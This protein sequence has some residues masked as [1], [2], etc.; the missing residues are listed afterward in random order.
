MIS[1]RKLRANRANSLRSTGPKTAAGRATAAR[2]ARRHGLRIPV[3]SDPA[4]SAE[5]EALAQKIAGNGSPELV[6]LAQKI[7]EAE[8]DVIRVRRARTDLI[9]RI[10]SNLRD[11]TSVDPG[12]SDRLADAILDRAMKIAQTSESAPLELR[13]LFKQAFEEL[14]RSMEGLE[15]LTRP[16]HIGP[17]FAIIDRYERRA[18]SRRK[19]A[20][21]A[22]DAARAALA[23]TAA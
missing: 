6:E 7:A 11:Q 20:I 23:S 12:F 3:L 4:L 9:S 18:L 17:E 15:F 8:I 10:D 1:P 5:V 21:R 13:D 19:F 2:N 14:D 16:P 22:F